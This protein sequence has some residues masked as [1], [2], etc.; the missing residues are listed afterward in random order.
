MLYDPKWAPAE[1]KLKPWQ[2]VLLKAAGILERDGW[3][4]GNYGD[5]S[6][7]YCTMGAMRAA[8]TVVPIHTWDGLPAEYVEACN[9][10]N[11]TLPFNI[12]YWNDHQDRTKE[13][14]VSTLR[15]VANAV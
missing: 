12:S 4:Q 11:E 8:S 13:E 2:E 1:I 7:G 10:L 6:R 14:V 9:K 3:I 5:E 15:K